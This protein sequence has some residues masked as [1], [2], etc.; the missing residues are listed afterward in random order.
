[1]GK[2]TDE[3][4]QYAQEIERK[5]VDDKWTLQQIADTYG[6]S[7]PT[8]S[9]FLKIRGVKIRDTGDYRPSTANRRMVVECLVNAGFDD[10][11]IIEQLR[12]SKIQ[13][14]ALKRNLAYKGRIGRKHVYSERE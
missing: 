9:R 2:K 13:L 4:I 14:R 8:I 12:I 3:L 7:I 11:V 5:Y 6:C 10:R 1:M